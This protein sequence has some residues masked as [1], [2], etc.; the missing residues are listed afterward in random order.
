MGKL[1]IGTGIRSPQVDGCSAVMGARQRLV[2]ELSPAADKH[3]GRIPT[4]AVALD[5]PR[6]RSGERDPRL[7]ARRAIGGR[8]KKR[9]RS[10]PARG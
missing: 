4:L 6:L 1:A 10:G 7:G 9:E 8:T 2:C 3:T 5:L